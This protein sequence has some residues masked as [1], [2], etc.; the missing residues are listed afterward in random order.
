MK[1]IAVILLVVGIGLSALGG[2]GYFFSDDFEQCRRASLTAE[3]KLNEARAA[4]GTSREAALIKEARMEVDSQEFFCRNAK[5]TEQWTMLVGLGG[6]A[7]VIV[8]L[9][10]LVIRRK[11]GV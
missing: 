9:V 8:S 11:S 10:L 5:R 2:Y 1:I 4:Q 3:E 6:F 7:A